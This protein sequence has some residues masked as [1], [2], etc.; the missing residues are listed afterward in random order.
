MAN[1]FSSRIDT[2]S[3]IHLF[4]LDGLGIKENIEHYI[5]I[6]LFSKHLNVVLNSNQVLKNKSPSR[7]NVSK[8][9]KVVSFVFSNP[10]ASEKKLDWARFTDVPIRNKIYYLI[11]RF[12]IKELFY[13]FLI[14]ILTS[15]I[16]N[17]KSTSVKREVNNSIKKYELL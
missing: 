14:Y 16:F 10:P 7:L 15:I 17:E 13:K 1:Y 4:N 6:K 12:T 11:V 9:Q 8:I 5:N 2:N 3:K